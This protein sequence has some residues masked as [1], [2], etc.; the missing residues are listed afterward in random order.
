MEVRFK[1]EGKVTIKD[2]PMALFDAIQD[3]LWEAKNCE[4]RKI[5]GKYVNEV[6]FSCCLDEEEIA[7]LDNIN[8]TL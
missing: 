8:W 7:E 6:G 4:W 2:I 5:D 1:E 3:I